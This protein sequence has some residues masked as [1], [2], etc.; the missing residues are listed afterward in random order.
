MLTALD[1]A[2]GGRAPA[3]FF[4]PFFSWLL[5]SQASSLPSSLAS[6][7]YLSPYEV[8]N[9]CELVTRTAKLSNRLCMHRFVVLSTHDERMDAW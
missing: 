9:Q 5:F 6:W 8:A 1:V 3:F 2:S 4:T 7:P